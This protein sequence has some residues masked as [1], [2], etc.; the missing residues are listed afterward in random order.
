M[1]IVIPASGRGQRFKDAG[2]I[3]PKPL[4]DVAGKP[5]LSR[6]VA[7]VMPHGEHRVVAAVAPGTPEMFDVQQVVMPWVTDGAARTAVVAIHLAQLPLHDPLLIANSDQLLDWE[8]QDFL[9]HVEPFDGGIV[10]FQSDMNPKWSYVQT[11]GRRVLKVVEKQ[12]ISDLATAGIYYWART[13]DFLTAAQTMIGWDDRHNNEFYVAPTYNYLIH[14]GMNI[15]T[16]QVNPRCMHGLGTPEDLRT[17]LDF[18]REE[19]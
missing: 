8:V 10:V 2:Y 6:V 14:A 13:A 18:L 16:Y 17:Y 3:L 11:R 4:I 9:N 19:A 12:P 15:Q 1:N 5:M 7:N